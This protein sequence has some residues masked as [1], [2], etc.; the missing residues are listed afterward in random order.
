MEK[1]FLQCSAIMSLHY[2][3]LKS[4]DKCSF[5]CKIQFLVKSYRPESINLI[6]TTEVS[7]L[8]TFTVFVRIQASA[9]MHYLVIVV[10]PSSLHPTVDTLVLHFA[11][12]TTCAT[13]KNI[14]S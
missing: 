10:P 13:L 7:V 3:Q 5:I 4:K 9:L 14:R 2:N 6:L 1:L 8:L 11:A 12:Q